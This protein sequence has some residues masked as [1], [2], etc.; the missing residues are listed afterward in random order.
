MKTWKFYGWGGGNVTCQ[1]DTVVDALK[2]SGG[3]F[4]FVR[5]E[6]VGKEPQTTDD[7]D[8]LLYIAERFSRQLSGQDQREFVRIYDKYA[9][10]SKR[11]ILKELNKVV[12]HAAW[13]ARNNAA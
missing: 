3:L 7:V 1:G 12:I 11:T 6:E 9:P 4:E 8:F 5:Y 10:N 2:A 13:D